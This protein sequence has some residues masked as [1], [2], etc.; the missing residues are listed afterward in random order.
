[1][2]NGIKGAAL[3][4]VLA[5]GGMVSNA[6]GLASLPFIENFASGNA[7][8]LNGASVSA[9]WLPSGGVDDGGYITANTTVVNT[10]FGAAA[11]R[12][13]AASDASGDAFVGDWLTGGVTLFTTYVRHNA[14]TNLD[15]YSRLDAGAGRAGSAVS[16]S[17]APNTWTLMSVPIVDSPTSFQAYGGGTFTTVFNSI[18]NVQV[19]LAP[20][21]DLAGQTYTIDLDQVSV[22]PEPGTIGLAAG[23]GLLLIGLRFFRNRKR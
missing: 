11:F 14:P 23:A 16:V 3:A 21:T 2:I 19:W 17:V 8:W 18:Q 10:G 15:I 22:V 9:T 13:N 5:A 20:N 4:A 7:N 1:M 12:G 6:F